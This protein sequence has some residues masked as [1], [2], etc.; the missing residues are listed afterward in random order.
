MEEYMIN[1]FD[2]I[3]TLL[4]GRV[5]Y[6]LMLSYWPTVTTE[7]PIITERM[8][9]LPKIVFSRTL[10]KVE[11]NA[12]LGKDNIVQEITHLKQQPGKDMVI[13]GGAD[14]A[15]TFMQMDLID[16]FR[17]IVNPVV[18]GR[19][20]PLFKRIR[21]KLNLKLTGTKTFSCGNAILIYQPAK[22]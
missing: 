16:E 19:G 5:T 13:F 10:E 11:W 7:D 3:D 21:G 6:E 22:G 1:F 18:L 20:T 14:L 12:R 17:L 9:N 2:T 4:F 15:S 8:N